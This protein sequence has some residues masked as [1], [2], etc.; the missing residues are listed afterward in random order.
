MS[1]EAKAVAVEQ[2]KHTP[3]PWHWEGHPEA[4]GYVA[5]ATRDSDVILPTCDAEWR[6]VASVWP[7]DA[8]LVAAAP[9]LLANLMRLL[10]HF[11]GE[12]SDRSAFPE[13]AASIS[14]A[15]AAVAKATTVF[16]W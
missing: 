7:A 12:M 15:K 8:A 14:E 13:I 4:V 1:E 16:P 10:A 6:V 11:D 3:G 9:D 5:L 2:P